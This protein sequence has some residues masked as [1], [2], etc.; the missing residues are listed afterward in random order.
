[1]HVLSDDQAFESYKLQSRQ[2]YKKALTK[3]AN[4]EPTADP[5]TAADKGPSE[6]EGLAAD[7]GP[8]ADQGPASY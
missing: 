5:G 7:K 3:A 4:K 1:M 8:A 6:D 2:E